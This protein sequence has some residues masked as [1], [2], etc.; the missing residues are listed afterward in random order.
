MLFALAALVVQDASLDAFYKFK[1]ETAWTY[2]RLEKDVERKV[3]ARV[4]GEE[5]G[6]VKLEWKELNADGSV[7][8]D[9]EVLWYMKDGVLRAE[10][11]IKDQ[12]G[13]ELPF[14]KAGTKKGETWSNAEGESTFL[15]TEEVKTI[16]G[17]YKDALHAR[18]NVG[19]AD[20]PTHIEFYFAPKVGLVKLTIDSP[21]GPNSFELTEFK[22]AK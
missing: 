19:S 11:R 3:S 10:V 20:A 13:F 18:L 22:E 9:S 6:R 14:L 15:G 8:A 21:E 16:A 1:P 2:K 12:G 5:N 4:L 17:T 7:H